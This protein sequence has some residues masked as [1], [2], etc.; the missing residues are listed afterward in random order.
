MSSFEGLELHYIQSFQPLT[1]HQNM[2]QENVALEGFA[3]VLDILVICIVGG[4]ETTRTYRRQQCQVL[5][6]LHITR[7]SRSSF[8]WKKQ[9]TIMFRYDS[10]KHC[11]QNLIFARLN[12]KFPILIKCEMERLSLS[13]SLSLSGSSMRGTRREGSFTGDPK[14]YAK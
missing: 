3:T 12:Q 7:P 8:F 11:P 9:E 6:S 13:L 2:F 4:G 5:Y 10:I 14:G 1:K